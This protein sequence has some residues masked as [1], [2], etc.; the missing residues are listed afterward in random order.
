MKISK[1][2]GSDFLITVVSFGEKFFTPCE[3]ERLTGKSS[4]RNWKSLIRCCGRPLS[5]FIEMCETSSGK[6]RRFVT[7]TSTQPS[8]MVSS[9]S[10]SVTGQSLPSLPDFLS[11][12]EAQFT[13]GSMDSQSFCH[14]L[15]ATYQEVVHWRSNCF[16]IP[17]GNVTKKFVLQK[18]SKTSKSKDHVSCIERR[19][20]LWM[21]GNL[22]DLV[23]EGRAIQQRL[24]G[25][26]LSTDTSKT[27]GRS[28]YSFANFMFNG[29][30][31]NALDMLSGRG[32]GRL[33]HLSE[34]VDTKENKTVRDVLETKHP[35]AAPLYPECLDTNSDS[36]LVFHPII[37]EALDGSVIRAAA[38]RTSGSA[39][40]SGLDAYG[41]R[42]LCSSFQSASDELCCSLAI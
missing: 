40:P 26:Q 38:L 7:S 23:L 21:D 6:K 14:A 27:D 20:H 24:N 22:N 4:S 15:E 25:K 32:K 2:C 13:W 12:A 17:N 19:L 42:R 33:L 36:S 31:K 10:S 18:P 1:S 16:K 37:F 5:T 8:C 34:I 29:K 9:E 41:W 39:G 3:F 28:A 35:S 11:V 30:T